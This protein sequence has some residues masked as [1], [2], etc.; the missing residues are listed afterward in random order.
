MSLTTH[1]S[2][3]SGGLTI[4]QRSAGRAVRETAGGVGSS[5]YFFRISRFGMIGYNKENIA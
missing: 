1:S 5:T 3:L 4:D 2:L